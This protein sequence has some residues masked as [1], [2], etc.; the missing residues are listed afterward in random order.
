MNYRK[1][2]LACFTAYVVQA[3]VNNLAPLL[4]VIFKR[5]LGLSLAQ[6]G[7]LAT[8]NFSVQMAADLA[9]AAV[10]SRINYRAMMLAAHA[11]SA[12][13]LIG[14]SF[15]PRLMPPFAGILL[16]VVLY[17]VGGG[18][19]EVLVSPLLEALPLGDKASAMSLLHSFYCWGHVAVV[20]LSTLFFRLAGAE[21]WAVLPLLWAVVPLVNLC[22]FAGAPIVRLEDDAP[23]MPRRALLAAKEFWL[24]LLIMVCAGASEQGMSQWASAFAEDGLGVG[25]AVGDLLGPCMFAA[26]MGSARVFFGKK[27]EKID[28]RR[29]MLLCGALCAA[30]YLLAGLSPLSLPAL[31]GCGLCGLAVGIMWPGTFSLASRALPAGGTAMFALLALGGDIGCALGPAVVGLSGKL[32]TGLPLCAVFPAALMLCCAGLKKRKE[33]NKEKI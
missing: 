6:L 27:G 31:A 29:F 12:V 1:T 9:A 23:A 33:I 5:E 24:F 15:F 13:G 3:I 16:A 30:G 7:L 21:S 18:L 20:L 26:L 19:L 28:L 8:L 22:V 10:G 32:R 17:A 11:L 4:F 25:K 2:Q 14:L